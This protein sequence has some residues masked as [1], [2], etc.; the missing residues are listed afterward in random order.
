MY[1]IDIR[2]IELSGQNS[3]NWTILKNHTVGVILI[4]FILQ[5]EISDLLSFK[6]LHEKWVWEKRVVSL[7]NQHSGKLRTNEIF[8]LRVDSQLYL[9]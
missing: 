5:S 7:D 8:Q 9:C 6:R 3:V 1:Q 2:Y 4:C